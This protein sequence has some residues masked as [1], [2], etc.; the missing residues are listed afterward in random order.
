MHRLFSRQFALGLRRMEMLRSGQTAALDAM[1]EIPEAQVLDNALG[2]GKG[3][4][5][6]LPHCHASIAVVRAL[7]AR[8][9]VLMLV[10][11]S[12]KGSRAA[13]QQTYYDHLGCDCIDVRRTG[14]AAVARAVLGAL[15]GGKLVVGVVDRLQKAPPED[16]PYNK[17]RDM[18][19]VTAFGQPVGWT[20]W[21]VRFAARIGS[22]ILPGMVTQTRDS[23]VLHLSAPR[24]PGPLVPATQEIA[25]NLEEL[26]RAFP[27]EWVFLYDKHW[28][29][30]LSSAARAGTASPIKQS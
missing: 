19:R 11:E 24:T 9:P 25:Q 10:R 6:A 1:L 13:A 17:E 27:E 12:K 7:A 21:P 5:L 28:R 23:M 3:A 15:R 20:G 2:Q 18:V 26:V 29:R 30:V 14:D 22:P 4:V 16:I 8:Y